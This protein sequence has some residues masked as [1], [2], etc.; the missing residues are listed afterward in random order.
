M[1]T[2]GSRGYAGSSRTAPATATTPRTTLTYRHQR[3]D[4]YSVR[5]PPSSS[6]TAPPAPAMA[7]KTPNA[8]PRSAGL[9]NVTVSVDSAAG[10]SIAPNAPCAPRPITSIAKLVAAPPSAVAAAKPTRPMISIRRRPTRSDSRPPSSSSPPK[11]SEYAV[12]THCRSALENP[13]ARWAEGSAMFTIVASRTTISWASPTTPRTHQRRAGPA[14][15]PD[16]P[17]RSDT[18]TT[19]GSLITGAYVRRGRLRKAAYSSFRP[20][21]AAAVVRSAYQARYG[22]GGMS[23]RAI[24]APVGQTAGSDRAGDASCTD[25]RADLDQARSIG[26]AWER[27]A[28]G[29][30]DG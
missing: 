30:T 1:R 27:T 4:R 9:V 19:V 13:S 7:P 21:P 2:S 11:A 28:T 25:P 8:L 23:A 6:P 10:A 3:Q 29:G 17:A 20:I 22:D 24:T 26:Q 15:T 5:N 18:A 16:D 12:T 14:A